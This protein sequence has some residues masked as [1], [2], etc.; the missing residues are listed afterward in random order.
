MTLSWDW[1]QRGKAWERTFEVEGTAKQKK[2]LRGRIDGHAQGKAGRLKQ[3][4]KCV[5]GLGVAD[6]SVR[7]AQIHLG[8]VGSPGRASSKEEDL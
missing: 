5:Y 2:I 6:H 4:E 8:M 1:R 3:L 7:G